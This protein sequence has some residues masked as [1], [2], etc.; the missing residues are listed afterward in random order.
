MSLNLPSGEDGISQLLSCH[1]QPLG[2][3]ESA[4][5]FG[6]KIA[7]QQTSRGMESGV[8]CSYA[9]HSIVA[10]FMPKYILVN[11][12]SGKYFPMIKL[13]QCQWMKYSFERISFL[14]HVA[15]HIERDQ[16]EDSICRQSS[17]STLLYKPSLQTQTLQCSAV[18]NA[19][20][21]IKGFSLYEFSPF[22]EIISEMNLPSTILHYYVF[23]RWRL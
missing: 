3:G 17:Q 10:F 13:D 23:I 9:R 21:L 15:P 14:S 22:L 7:Q 2:P 8:N 1:S 6:Q 18:F 5:C 12:R 4:P 19:T 20:H 16:S 11:P